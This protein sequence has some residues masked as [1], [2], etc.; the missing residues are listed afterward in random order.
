MIKNELEKVKKSFDAL[1][2]EM[3]DNNYRG[4]LAYFGEGRGSVTVM[5][6]DTALM[7]ELAKIM[8]KSMDSV[9]E[10]SEEFWESAL[11]LGFERLDK[12][13]RFMLAVTMLAK[14]DLEKNKVDVE[15]IKREAL[16]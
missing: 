16:N 5:G 13:L 15:E 2:E 11:G 10:Q 6:A 12:D 1:A 8:I 9:I 7:V 3:A 14:I 4:V